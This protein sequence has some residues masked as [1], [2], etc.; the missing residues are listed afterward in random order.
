M[1]LESRG[2]HSFFEQQPH[3]SPSTSDDGLEFAFIEAPLDYNDPAGPRIS[4]AISR[5]RAT[6]PG[7]RR[8]TLLSLNGGPGGDGGLGRLLPARLGGRTPLNEIYDLVGF[9]P[10]GTGASTR[11]EGENSPT[12]TAFDSRPPDSAFE[13]ITADMQERDQGCVRA[14]G[15]LRRHITT[16]NNARDMDLIRRVLGEE[17]I[18][19]VGWAYGT[20]LG[21]V[22]GTMFGDHLDRNVLDSSVHPDWDWRRQFM[23]QADA[24]RENVDKWA[25]WAAE[26]H[27]R[28]E[29]GATPARVLESVE[30]TAA[31][32]VAMSD[33][34]AARTSFDG[35][36]GNLS[37]V[38]PKW[39]ELAD[40]V[41][42]LGAA[43]DAGDVDRALS[44]LAGQ[45]KW[46]PGY[47]AGQLREAVLEAVTCET[48]WPT[49]L[50]IYYRDMRH[51]REHCP[52][53]FGVMRA[54][55]WVGT[56]RTAL[57]TE[58]ATRLRRTGY[59]T[60]IVVQADGDPW[61][62]H[63]GALA[64]AERLGHHLITVVDSGGHEIYG[65]SGNEHVDRLVNDYLMNGTLP[66]ERVTCPGDPRPDITPHRTRKAPDGH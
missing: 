11:I 9:D 62:Y 16:R 30:K 2:P 41:R 65:L 20:L 25:E 15:E 26:H 53:G 56:F 60:G 4:L 21:A 54:Q 6:D 63:P 37:P 57:P 3:W 55:P 48:E 33:N 43:A 47:A 44:L 34:A 51:Y 40:L 58:P 8:G 38:R 27:E 17:K 28:F 49:D 18:S 32:L 22:Y 42:E 31:A 39:A 7:R 45:V 12:T 14:G 5:L 59:P 36:V 66:P 35:A 46:R 29:L 10:R 61:D 24:V 1:T 13:A 52:Y 23:S 64:M 19:Y 50:E